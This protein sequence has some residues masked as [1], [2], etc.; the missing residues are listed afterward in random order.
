M[1]DNS[2]VPLANVPL[3]SDN[4]DCDSAHSANQQTGHSHIQDKL[5]KDSIVHSRDISAKAQARNSHALNQVIENSATVEH[6]HA[7]DFTQ[8]QDL[9]IGT[10]PTP[11]KTTQQKPI[12]V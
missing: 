1:T 7:S 2:N 11:N 12:L 3:N 6:H 8:V 4:L 9:P 10:K 5:V